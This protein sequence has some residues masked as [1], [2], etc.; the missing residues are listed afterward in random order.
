MRFMGE[1]EGLRSKTD[2]T[3]RSM[4]ERNTL[5]KYKCFTMGNRIVVRGGEGGKK[6]RK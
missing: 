5:G 6:V 2:S 3:D 1:K 4:A